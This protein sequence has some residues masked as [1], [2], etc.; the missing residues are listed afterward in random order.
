MVLK[1]FKFIDLIVFFSKLVLF[2]TS[3]KLFSIKFF[4]FASFSLS[5]QYRQVSLIAKKAS[6]KA[7]HF[8][9]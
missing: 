1:R 2:M 4:E 9:S 7:S 6:I 5:S 3:N 8:N